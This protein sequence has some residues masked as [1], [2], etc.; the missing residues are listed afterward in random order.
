MVVSG[1]G[2]ASLFVFLLYAPVCLFYYWRL[3]PCLSPIAKHLASAMLATQVLAIMVG[4][5]YTQVFDYVS[6]LWHLDR[7]FNI[8]AAIASSQI[9]LVAGITLATAWLAPKMYPWQR[10]LLAGVGIVF[11]YLAAD[12]YFTFHEFI[13]DWDIRYGALG[14]VVVVATLIVAAYSPPHTWKWYSSVLTGLAISAVGAILIERLPTQIPVRVCSDLGWLHFN[15]CLYT[16]KIEESLELLGIWLAL[17][18]VLGL[19]SATISKPP[20]LIRRFLYLL[21]VLWSLLLFRPYFIP[22]LEFCCVA[23]SAEV[24]YESQIELQAY[25]ISND[26][27][28]FTLQLFVSPASWVA[29]DGL[30]YSVQLV[31]QVTG[32]AIAGSDKYATRQHEWHFGFYPDL[33]YRQPMEFEIPPETPPNRALWVVLTLWREQDGE[34]VHQEVLSSDHEL[35]SDSQVILDELVLPAAPADP[36]ALPFAIFDNGFTLSPVDLPERA[37]AGETLT[38]PFA[39]HSDA[40]GEEDHVQFLHLGHEESGAWWVYDQ[41]P[42]GARLPTR[43]WYDGLADSEVWQ[44][45]LSSDLAPGRYIVYTGLYRSRD[46]ER[47][48]VNDAGGKLWLDARVLLGS[49]MIE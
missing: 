12:E 3:F 42:L 38:I 33:R 21:P 39:W 4:L 35:L 24:E 23:E 29:Y 30:G 13:Q 43:L 11:L 25:R 36:A 45:P 6:W 28:R 44:V 14:G 9:A 49:L 34:F 26:E 18:G 2:F 22:F 10:L 15:P 17:V 16:F 7:E 37:Q 47:I 1:D 31:D 48:P 19:L 40:N 32:Y 8:S 20:R 5:Q 46:Q 27:G 41:Q